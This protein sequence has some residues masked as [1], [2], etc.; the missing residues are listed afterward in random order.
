MPVRTSDDVDNA[1]TNSRFDK[2]LLAQ[3]FA[4]QIIPTPGIRRGWRRQRSTEKRRLSAVA[5]MLSW[6]HG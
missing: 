2:S 3:A 1:C 5:C 4:M 6:G